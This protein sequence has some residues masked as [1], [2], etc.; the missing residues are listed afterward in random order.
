MDDSVII[1]RFIFFSPIAIFIIIVGLFYWLRHQFKIKSSLS[2]CMGR[3]FNWGAVTAGAS[4]V[5]F[6]LWMVWIYFTKTHDLGQAPLVWIFG[7][8]PISFLI[9][10]IVGFII[11]SKSNLTN[12]R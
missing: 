12:S 8:G 2:D 7:F 4:L 5:V 11:W 1:F 6:I 3:C 10:T 9:G